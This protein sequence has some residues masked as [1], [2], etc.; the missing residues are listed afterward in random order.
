M[1]NSEG[2]HGRSQSHSASPQHSSATLQNQRAKKHARHKSAG[3][4]ATH[5]LHVD[6]NNENFYTCKTSLSGTGQMGTAEAPSTY[7][8]QL[9]TVRGSRSQTLA[10]PI[11]RDRRMDKIDFSAPQS[12]IQANSIQANTTKQQPQVAVVQQ[13][14]RDERVQQ[15]TQMKSTLQTPVKNDRQSA[16]YVSL[17]FLVC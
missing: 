1:G 5:E 17:A 16:E 11:G 7:F 9:P 2:S 4:P 8:Y 13:Q 3:V 10:A 12:Q 6:E 14:T 15:T